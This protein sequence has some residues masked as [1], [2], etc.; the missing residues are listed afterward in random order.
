MPVFLG[1]VF[2]RLF[3]EFLYRQPDGYPEK[4]RNMWPEMLLVSG[5]KFCHLFDES[6][7]LQITEI[8]C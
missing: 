2:L 5:L 4:D 6:D 8:A 1:G 7:S 3:Q